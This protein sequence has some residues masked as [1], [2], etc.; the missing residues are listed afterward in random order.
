MSQQEKNEE[1]EDYGDPG[2]LLADAPVPRWLIFNY[3][4]WPIWGIATFYLFWNG[5]HGWLDRV[6][7]AAVAKGCEHYPSLH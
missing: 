1:I 4:L 7:L 2:V 6:L 5:S 3:I